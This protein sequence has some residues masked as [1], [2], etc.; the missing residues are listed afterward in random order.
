MP[1]RRKTHT[2]PVS[3]FASPVEPLPH[4]MSKARK[5]TRELWESFFT[6]GRWSAWDESQ[7]ALARSL[8]RTFE[9]A[10]RAKSGTSRTLLLRE[11][12]LTS[13]RLGLL[14]APKRKKG[15]PQPG[16][17]DAAVRKARRDARHAGWKAK[18]VAKLEEL[19]LLAAGD[20]SAE[21]IQ[22]AE[23]SLAERELDALEA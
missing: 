6:S 18:C 23:A 13:G 3:P 7:Q 8:L 15:M 1:A 17:E 10:E 9:E 12:R 2:A 16:S 4:G 11:V 22:A 19:G 5:A 14:D 21:V 20:R